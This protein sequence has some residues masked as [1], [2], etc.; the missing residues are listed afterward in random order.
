MPE[1]IYA[2]PCF[3]AIQPY[4][5]MHTATCLIFTR[6]ITVQRTQQYEIW[7]KVTRCHVLPFF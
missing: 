3:V 7:R 1:A 2:Y 6:L 5:L 4:N